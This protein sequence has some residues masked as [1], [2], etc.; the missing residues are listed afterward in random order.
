MY[1]FFL[2]ILKDNKLTGFSTSLTDA[3]VLRIPMQ[4]LI[5]VNL[6]IPLFGFQWQ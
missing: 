2:Q 3:Q 6:E 1:I 5:S 4:N